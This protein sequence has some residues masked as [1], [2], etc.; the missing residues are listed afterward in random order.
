[1]IYYLYQRMSWFSVNWE[2]LVFI[3]V[4]MIMLFAYWPG[5]KGN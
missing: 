1:M 5:K 4:I 2:E 3:G